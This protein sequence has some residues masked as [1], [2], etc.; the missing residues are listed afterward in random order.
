MD[1]FKQIAAAGLTL[2][3]IKAVKQSDLEPGDV[4]V[5]KIRER[6]GYGDYRRVREIIRSVFGS[7]RKVLLL[8]DAVDIQFLRNTLREAAKS[9]R[10]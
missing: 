10:S 9:E 4:V 1:I 7:E 5:L 3:E 6:I 8:E 2:T